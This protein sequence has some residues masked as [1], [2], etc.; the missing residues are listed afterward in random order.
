MEKSTA[1]IDRVT[2]FYDWAKDNNTLILKTTVDADTIKSFYNQSDSDWEWHNAL[3]EGISFLIDSFLEI[4]NQ[5]KE[6]YIQG[7]YS[8]GDWANKVFAK[9]DSKV[10]QCYRFLKIQWLYNSIKE[11]CQHAPAQLIKFRKDQ[12][13]FHPGSDKVH[14]LYMLARQEQL[15]IN[16]FYIWYKDLDP[17]LPNNIDFDVVNTPNDFADMFVKF[18]DKRFKTIEG[19]ASINKE[20]WTTDQLHFDV[21]CKFVASVLRESDNYTCNV[22][23][24]CRH[25]S[26][27][28]SVHHDGID[29]K[30][31]DLIYDYT[32]QEENGKECFTFSNGL[33]YI[34]HKTP[35][36]WSAYDHIWIPETDI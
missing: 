29:I 7:K 33:K 16:L 23:F 20:D 28:D 3:Y 9:A 17:M 36:S 14:A 22:P 8:R 35:S 19:H 32:L 10:Y 11:D 2:S 21:F 4:N 27:N 12:Y 26:Y 15:P 34:K 31:T 5:M 25:I 18:N 1:N 30:G 6:D 13:R 24:D